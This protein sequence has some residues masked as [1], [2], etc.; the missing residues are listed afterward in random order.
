[1]GR[2]INPHLECVNPDLARSK[3]L[4][5]ATRV[6]AA[7]TI[8]SNE[9]NSRLNE[10]IGDCH[11]ILTKVSLY[12]GSNCIGR[13]ISFLIKV[14][15]SCNLEARRKSQKSPISPG[16]GYKLGFR[17]GTKWR[18]RPRREIVCIPRL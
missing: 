13:P 8:G 1:M 4:F 7:G 11:F 5:N 12:W 18:F 2:T 6:I 16:T 17:I 9:Q 3:R 14:V 15:A 10:G